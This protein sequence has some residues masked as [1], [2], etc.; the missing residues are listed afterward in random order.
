M[1]ALIL[2]KGG[3]LESFTQ[4]SFEFIACGFCLCVTRLNAARSLWEHGLTG[5][6]Y[7]K[8]VF[9]FKYAG[10][11]DGFATCTTAPFV[12]AD[13]WHTVRA[14][15]IL[16]NASGTSDLFMFSEVTMYGSMSAVF[17]SSGASSVCTST[18]LSC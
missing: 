17:V 2:R 13:D 7:P 16:L 4:R 18:A 9:R 12:M 10:L 15:T 14:T 1:V 5:V 11:L 8:S 6:M 3:V